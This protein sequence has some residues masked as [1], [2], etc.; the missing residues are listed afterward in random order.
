MTTLI[1]QMMGRTYSEAMNWITVE[2]TT[3]IVFYHFVAVFRMVM[4]SIR[5]KQLALT[6]ERVNRDGKEFYF[7][8]QKPWSRHWLVR[9]WRSAVQKLQKWQ[10]L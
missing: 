1:L 4:H 6:Y 8:S 7:T 10:A 5:A 3:M 2:V 9:K